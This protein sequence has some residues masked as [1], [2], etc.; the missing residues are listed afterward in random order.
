MFLISFTGL[1][2]LTIISNPSCGQYTI[3]QYKKCASSLS[4]LGSVDAGSEEGWFCGE[5][6]SQGLRRHS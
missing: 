3:F 1:S 4:G 5:G 6:G 2:K